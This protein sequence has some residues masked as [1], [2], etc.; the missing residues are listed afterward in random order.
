M[1]FGASAFGAFGFSEFDDES[2]D[3]E[4]F[5]GFLARVSSPGCWVLELDAFPLAAAGVRAAD[6]GDAAFG[7][8]AFGD[9]DAG[10]A[11]GVVTLRYS[12]HGYV[13]HA[14]DLPARTWHDG[15]VMPEVRIERS[16][17]GRRG[18]GGLARVF[19]EISL[20]N[21]DGG[22]DALLRD[23]AIDGR[24]FRL[25]L[26]DP[27]AALSTFGVVCTGVVERAAVGL[28]AARLSLSD[29]AAR[30]EVPVS[31]TVYAG[32][33]GLEGGDDLR[34]K[35]KPRCYGVVR[36][37]APPLVD[38]A[39]L[40]YQV[41]DGAIQAVTAVYD[42]GIALVEVP[43]VPA[44]GEYSV[45]LSA[46]TFT[47]GATPAGTV[48]SDVEGDAPT[49]GY[50]SRTADIVQ[51]LLALADLTSSEIE[52]VSFGRLN[53]EAG[54][55]VGIWFGTEPR[56]VADA[57]DELLAGVGAWGGFNRH[58]AFAVGVIAAASGA[59]ALQ[60]GAADI[61][62][63]EREPMPDDV[64]PR[65]WRARVGW[66]KNYTV[67]GDLAAGVDAAMR[68]FAAEAWRVAEA[69][70]PAVKSRHLLA[71]EYGPVEALYDDEADA[72]AEADR[73]LTLWGGALGMYRVATRP[74]GVL[75]DIGA[76]LELTHPRHGLALGR[77]GRVLGQAVR[78]MDVEL[79]VLA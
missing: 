35:P 16:V 66:G 7:E 17:A 51:R 60:L 20:V 34:G 72:D 1:S 27:D 62:D 12:S 49:A 57:I 71:R 26:G 63:L 69:S 70:D 44:G 31:G 5:A 64:D 23:Y 47:L 15:R 14:D 75:A 45:D 3:S 8:L 25:L 40:V 29:G 74:I 61:V 18:I 50:V 68:T 53:T 43:G 46:G 65:I 48:T 13:S 55:T 56:T 59:P 22:L 10:G 78:G 54:A 76:V 67:Q 2:P 4:A 77:A 33:G 30:L 19:A 42:R 11:G 36:N 41:H 37:I 38:S 39:G 79:K 9:A 58:G 73:L 32:S 52:P 24:R 21:A 28:S 6:F